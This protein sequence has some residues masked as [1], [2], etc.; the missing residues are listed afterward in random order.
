MGQGEGR[1]GLEWSSYGPWRA[2]GKPAANR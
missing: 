1:A 2:R